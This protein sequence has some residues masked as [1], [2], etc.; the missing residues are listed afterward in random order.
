[1]V[2]G[3]GEVHDQVLDLALRQVLAKGL[4]EGLGKI[5]IELTGLRVVA[6]ARF[7]GRYRCSIEDGAGDADGGRGERAVDVGRQKGNRKVS[8]QRP[9]EKPILW[10]HDRLQD[11]RHRC[12]VGAGEGNGK[13]GLGGG[14]ELVGDGVV[15][16]HIGCLALR[17][18]LVGGIGGIEAVAA[19]GVEREPG[20]RGIEAEA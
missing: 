13:G 2:I 4:I 11:G 8:A 19:V 17:Q 5:E 7:A 20:D 12:I 16:H 1:M 15:G 10:D 6:D 18:V 3:D 14:A 9:L